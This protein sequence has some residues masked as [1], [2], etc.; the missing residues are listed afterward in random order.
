[1]LQHPLALNGRGLSK[2]VQNELVR[3]QNFTSLEVSFY[4][5]LDSFTSDLVQSTIP[6]IV[7]TYCAIVW[8]WTKISKDLKLF[9]R[10]ALCHKLTN[11]K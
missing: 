5:I 4:L 10:L 11:L 1:M 2:T 7:I 9:K 3:L 8:A 6:S